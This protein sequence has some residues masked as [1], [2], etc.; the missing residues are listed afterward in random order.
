MNES[1]FYI[2]AHCSPS[3]EPFYI[4][5]GSGNRAY[6]VR[7]SHSVEYVNTVMLH[8]RENVVV[9]VYICKS[10]SHALRCEVWMIA[11][12]SSH[13]WPLV[14]KTIGGSSGPH[15]ASHFTEEEKRVISRCISRAQKRAWRRPGYMKKIM[16]MRRAEWEVRRTQHRTHW[17]AT[18]QQRA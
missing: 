1:R 17:H 5:K 13:G 3:G 18:Q 4:G 14:N 11:Y 15:I 12:G 6:A 7:S 8:G 2:Y 10:E 9:F 16:V